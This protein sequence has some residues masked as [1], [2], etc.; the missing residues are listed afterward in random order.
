MRAPKSVDRAQQHLTLAC[1]EWLESGYSL[2]N[3]ILFLYELYG[4]ELAKAVR[5]GEVKESEYWGD[6]REAAL[7]FNL[8]QAHFDDMPFHPKKRTSR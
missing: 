3:L 2:S 5:S 8:Q 6:M 4:K 7:K 1:R